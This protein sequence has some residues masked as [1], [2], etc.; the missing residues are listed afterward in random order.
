MRA[1]AGVEVEVAGGVTA[2]VPAEIVAEIEERTT[3][4]GGGRRRRKNVFL[5]TRVVEVVV[6][7]AAAV[8]TVGAVEAIVARG[9]ETMRV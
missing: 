3:I 4:G 2:G 7:V 5:R 6:V 1:V 8:V 9:I